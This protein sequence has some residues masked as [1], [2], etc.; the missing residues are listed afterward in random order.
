[1]SAQDYEINIGMAGAYIA[2][3][4]KKNAILMSPDRR[5]ITQNEILSLIDWY[6][7]K[8]LK[9][10]GSSISFDSHTRE[11][12]RIHLAFYKKQ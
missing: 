4:N 5:E 9:N 3:T 12:E 2:R 10:G 8:Y 11:G 7:D 6:L 1:M